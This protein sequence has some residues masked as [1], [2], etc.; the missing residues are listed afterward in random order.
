[1]SV[2]EPAADRAGT[3]REVTRLDGTGTFAG[4]RVRSDGT[5]EL[6]GRV[7]YILGSTDTEAHTPHRDVDFT[8][9][10]GVACVNAGGFRYLYLGRGRD[11]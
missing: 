4:L 10:F 2:F 8:G 6:N 3:I 1:M 7:E 11:L 9:T 5:G